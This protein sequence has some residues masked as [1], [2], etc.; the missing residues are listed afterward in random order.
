MRA[1]QAEKAVRFQALH[2]GPGRVRP[3]VPRRIHGKPLRYPAGSTLSDVTERSHHSDVGSGWRLA[4]IG[5]IRYVVNFLQSDFRLAT[6]ESDLFPSGALS[7]PRHLK[8]QPRRP[9]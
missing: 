1:T 9:R 5:S 4:G 7:A 8:L 6:P 3:S 2:A